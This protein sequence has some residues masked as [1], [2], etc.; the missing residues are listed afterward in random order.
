M[1]KCNDFGV[2][3]DLQALPI[4]TGQ[5]PEALERRASRSLSLDLSA[6]VVGRLVQRAVETPDGVAAI[7]KD[8]AVTY[9]QLSCM[10]ADTR[11]ILQAN[12]CQQG[13][14][15]AMLG[16]RSITT[17]AI[18]LALESLGAVYLPLD[19]GWPSAHIAEVLKNSRST[20]VM[21]LQRERIPHRVMQAID[22]ATKEAGI[23]LLFASSNQDITDR[24]DPAE[25][26]HEIDRARCSS[27]EP[28]YLYFTSGT[29]GAPKGALI[30]HQ[31][32]I[33][34]LWAKITDV[35]LGREDTL[36]FTAP[37]VFDI[38][39]CQML[40]PI[41]TGATM[42]VIDDVDI[43]S[44]GRLAG[45]LSR[46]S[47]T[48]VELVPTIIG[49]LVDEIS[50]SGA[51]KVPPLRWIISTGEELR[52]ALAKRVFE[53]FPATQLLNSYGFTECSDDIAHYR[54]TQQDL[55]AE[56]LPV[57]SPIINAELYVLVQD[58]ES[59]RPA[60]G[61]ERG[62][63]FVGG[64]PVGRGYV[65]NSTATRSA[66]F[67]DPFNPSSE[68]GRIYRTGD[69]VFFDD[70]GRLHLVGRIGRQLKISGI[71]VEPDEVE[72]VLNRHP[73]VAACAVIPHHM[74]G[75]TE[76]AAYFVVQGARLIA[77]G[78]LRSYLLNRLPAPMV[79]SQWFEIEKI[80]MSVNGKTDYSALKALV[81]QPPITA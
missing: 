75:Y 18:F 11:R 51:S 67:Q 81:G 76:L 43:R 62:E 5:I 13:S 17:V 31:G 70:D 28:R 24:M 41:L 72:A 15:V 27:T 66:F 42:A 49:W 30:E 65:G 25:A 53:T 78:D 69:Q 14:V 46:N 10:V 3:G 44:P 22:E 26:L 50:G 32:M 2:T 58:G 54:V 33:N 68:T 59:W 71:R 73:G 34:H 1:Q 74:D 77:S 16:E 79:P 8:G 40:M 48:V 55:D 39:V 37:L 12:G 36:A 20:C 63:L 80:P 35:E 19:Y 6:T 4:L 47:V 61:G 29:T 45:V 64:L 38:A 9:R 60:E 23:A 21:A 52:P 56:R 7:S 57:G